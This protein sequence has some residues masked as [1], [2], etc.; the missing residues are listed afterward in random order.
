MIKTQ[1]SIFILL[2]LYSTQTLAQ[3]ILF[4]SCSHQDKAMP[5][6]Q[7]IN[8]ENADLFVFLGDNIYGDTIDMQAM[9]DKYQR[10]AENAAFNKLRENTEH[11]A[12]WDDHDYGENDAGRE[13][14]KKE[15]SRKLM[16]DFW[17]ENKNSPRYTRS[18][19]IYTSYDYGN[20]QQKVRVIMPDLRWNRSPL[21]SVS[22]SDYI[23]KRKPNNMGPY[24]ANS[25]PQ[26][27]MLGEQQWQWLENELK[28]PAKIKIIASS[29]QLLPEFSGWESW[30]NFP[31]DRN[32]L[33][34]F[35]KKHQ[36][37]GVIFIS[38][39][40]HWG[41]ISRVEKNL[42][43]P[44]Y[45][46]TSSGLTQEWKAVSPNKHRLGK[47]TSKVNYGELIIDWQQSDPAITIGLKNVTGSVVNLQQFNLSSISPY[48]Q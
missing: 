40:T 13:Y 34:N 48:K 22:R 33:L 43:Y 14:P 19:G 36:I 10:L 23:N 42:D 28:K 38:G 6:L 47:F 27:S 2:L 44:L 35:I 8:K 32:R 18:D 37:N 12:I 46:V 21:T 16:L 30:A 24:L 20:E 45:E 39:D 9:A 11:I 15:A 29:L 7:A 4:G 41:E 26:A 31:N 1:A 25:S 5:I 17:Q 3:K